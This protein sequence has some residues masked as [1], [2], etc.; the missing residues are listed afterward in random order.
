MKQIKAFVRCD[1]IDPVVRALEAAG[2]PGVSVSRV[3]GVG[4][5]YDPLIFG[6]APSRVEKAPAIAKVEVV[7]EDAA[8]DRL[9]GAL[10]EAART[11]SHGD[12]LLIVTPVESVIRIR[13]GE[14]GHAALADS[15]DNGRTDD[16]PARP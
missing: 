14:R 5:G 13:T 6:L 15:S 2:A 16:R 12:G 1:R 8:T 11:G 4:Y 7:C 10:A 9:A 3:H